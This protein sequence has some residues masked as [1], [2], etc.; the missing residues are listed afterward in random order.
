MPNTKTSELRYHLTPRSSNAKTGPIPVS[1]SSRKLCPS[2]CPFAAN[3][4][5]A[6]SGPLALH[7]REVTEG[8]RG[9]PWPEFLQAIR[10][11]PAGQLWRANQA[12]DIADPATTA[13]RRALKELTAANQGRRGF[14]YTHHPLTPSAIAALKGSTAQGFTVNASTETIGA[15]DRAVAYGLRAVTVVPSTDTRRFWRSPD[16]NP[17]V[18]CPAQVHEGL[19][20]ERCQLCAKRPQEVIVAF[21]AHGT[22]RKKVDAVL[23]QWEGEE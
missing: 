4:C 18:A 15:A 19:T 11:L 8:R 10:D 16:G 12:G 20:C 5:Y 22:S 9:M 21:R 3:G 17:V 7:W 6:A 14:T 1:T 2:S 23:A 13:G